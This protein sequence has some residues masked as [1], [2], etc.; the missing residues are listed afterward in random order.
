VFVAM[1]GAVHQPVEPPAKHRLDY[2]G[3]KRGDLPVAPASQPSVR[4]GA[5]GVAHEP[6][7][8]TL[9]PFAPGARG[10]GGDAGPALNDTWRYSPCDTTPNGLT[11]I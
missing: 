5:G 6:F 10:D 11:G 9:V 4:L 8:A 7:I 1:L 2:L 3:R